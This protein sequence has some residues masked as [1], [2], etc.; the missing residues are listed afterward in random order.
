LNNSRPDMTLEFAKI[1]EFLA[2]EINALICGN[3]RL[4]EAEETIIERK[5]LESKLLTN[6][7]WNSSMLFGLII[8]LAWC[9]ALTCEIRSLS[10]L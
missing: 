10:V 6:L 1:T 7:I 4:A 8:A 2:R 3:K 9:I 5:V